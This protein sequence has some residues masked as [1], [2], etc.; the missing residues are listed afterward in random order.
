MGSIHLVERARER[1][2]ETT[3]TPAFILPNEGEE[4]YLESVMLLG[5]LRSASLGI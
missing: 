3:V 2:N 5:S 1:V 4:I